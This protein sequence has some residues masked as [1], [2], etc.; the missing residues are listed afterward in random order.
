MCRAADAKEKWRRS[1][2]RNK[3]SIRASAAATGF[4]DRPSP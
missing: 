4:R 1:V 3:Q 2:P